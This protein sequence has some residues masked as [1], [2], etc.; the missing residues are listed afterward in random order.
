MLEEFRANAQLI[1]KGDSS[2]AEGIARRKGLGTVRHIDVHELLR[3]G[4]VKEGIIKLLR[5]G[6]ASNLAD[7]LTKRSRA[8]HVDQ[9]VIH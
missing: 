2:A 6:G 1:L 5:V 8:C 4:K 9:S 3:K 7:A